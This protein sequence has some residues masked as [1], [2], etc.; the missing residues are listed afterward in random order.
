[1]EAHQAQADRPLALGGVD[2][3]GHF[4]RGAVDEVLQHIVEE[5]HDVLDER[6]MVAPLQEGLGVDAGQAAD[7]GALLAQVVLARVQHDFRAQ[8][9][10]AHIEAQFPLMLRHRTVHGVGEDQVGL[11]SLQADLEDLLPQ[12]PGIDLADNLLGLGRAQAEHRAVAHRL[13]ELIR[14]A[15]PVVQVQALA[16]EIAGRFAD[17]EEFLDLRMVNVQIDG[18]RTAAQR[19]LADRQRQA[20]H[21]ADEGDDAAGLARTLHLLADRA[22]AAPIGADAAAVGGQVD[23]L[24]PDALDAFQTVRHRVQEA[25]DRQAPTRPAVRQ[26][27]RRR[28]EPQLRNVVVNP[29]RMVG[30]VGVGRRDSREHV[31]IALAGQQIP[32]FQR[33]LAEIGQQGVA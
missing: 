1:M 21:H 24:V 25:R 22:H 3:V 7:R 31:L 10:L 20:V 4:R 28:H 23:I 16:V 27:R 9:G 13:H 29:L 32:V 19:T 8:V 14:N 6:R 11:A 2:G 33:R 15:D 5:A 17:L 18:R 30:I 12:R 26:H